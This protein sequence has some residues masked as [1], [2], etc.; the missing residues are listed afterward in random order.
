MLKP[1]YNEATVGVDGEAYRLVINFRT[2]DAIESLLD[3]DFDTVLEE[4]TDVS[5]RARHGLQAKVV[6][7]LLREHHS[8]VTLDQA[9]RLVYGDTGT[10][11]GLVIADLIEAAFPKASTEPEKEKG[12]NPPKPRGASKP[13]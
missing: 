13:S 2:I 9:T 8:D 10:A 11:V 12:K 6:W 5:R 3:R 4:L 1:F 7:G